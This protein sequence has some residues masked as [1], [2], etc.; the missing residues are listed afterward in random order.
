MLNGQDC[1]A[2]S[3]THRSSMNDSLELNL[4]LTVDSPEIRCLS[5]FAWYL[6]TPGYFTRIF[7]TSRLHK[8]SKTFY[9]FY[10]LVPESGNSGSKLIPQCSFAN[11]PIT[12][13][14]RNGFDYYNTS[15]SY[16]MFTDVYT[17]LSLFNLTS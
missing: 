16:V 6:V 8:F 3:G 12:K 1:R 14:T 10:F 15:V 11:L 5:I 13:E 7:F 4:T 9:R 17:L 2:A